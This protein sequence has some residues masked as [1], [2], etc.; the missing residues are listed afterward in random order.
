MKIGKVAHKQKGTWHKGCGTIPQV[1][2]K[3]IPAQAQS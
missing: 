1:L 3:V 2:L